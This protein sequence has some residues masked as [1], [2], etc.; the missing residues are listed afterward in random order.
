V[1]N[2]QTTPLQTKEIARRGKGRDEDEEE[3]GEDG[4]A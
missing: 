1:S 2:K 4:R 3:R